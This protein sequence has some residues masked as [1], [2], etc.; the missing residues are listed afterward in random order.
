MAS[1]TVNYNDDR[2]NK[3]EQEK[4]SEL[5]KYNQKYDQ[6]IN[7]RNDFTNQQ[8]QL[9]NQWQQTQ[10]KIANDNLNFQKE[11]YEQQ[12]QKAEEEYQKEAKA[13]Y[14]DYQKEVD[15]YGVSRENVVSNGLSNSGYSESSKVDMYNTYQNRVASARSSLNDAKLE[16]DNAIKEA[17]LTNNA[18]LAE[19]ALTALQQKLQIALEGFNYKTEQENNRLNW[20]YTINDTY[21]NRYQDVEDQINY[22]NQQAE[23]IRQWNEQ[24]AFQKQQAELTQQQ[25]EKEYALQQQQL[26][27]ERE[28]QA[29]QQAYYQSLIDGN[30]G[31]NNTELNNSSSSSNSKI[32]GTDAGNSLYNRLNMMKKQNTLGMSS[33][34]MKDFLAAQVNSAYKKGEINSADV[35]NILNKLGIK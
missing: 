7:E 26:A 15:K 35:N 23:A 22:E 33:S 20:N 2:F 31:G 27:M 28:S 9:V 17:T 21:Y 13:S 14:I 32:M 25:W 10:D 24:M 3:V 8:Q 11:L 1:Y 19:N 6:L 4:Q 5:D 34:Q 16:F 18:Q 30:G 29:R 12:K